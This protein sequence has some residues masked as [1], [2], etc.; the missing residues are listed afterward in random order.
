MT[1]PSVMTYCKIVGRFLLAKTDS[2]VDLDLPKRATIAALMA[3][4]LL[5]L[6]VSPATAAEPPAAVL[7]LSGVSA[8]RDAGA[9]MGLRPGVL[10]RS[11]KLCKTPKSVD[12]TIARLLAGGR[13]IDLRTASVARG[14]KDPKLS[15]V[16]GGR[17]SLPGTRNLRTFVTSTS[18]RKTI[19]RILAVIAAEDG[20]VWVHCTRGRDRTGWLV[21]VLG[22]IAGADPILI[23]AEYLRTSGA[24]SS[25]YARGLALV[26]TRWGGWDG[27][28]IRGLG[29]TP[30]TLDALRAK[31]S[32]TP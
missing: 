3:A 11:A 31:L 24:R 27:Y 23:R 18:A 1:L 2:I 28:L 29:L 9:G 16:T 25:D 13:I 32:L 12:A 20:P 21:T 14:C 6:T 7:A 4:L 30:A 26:D 5:T 10:Y 15:G 17:Y 8:E 19:T 22:Y